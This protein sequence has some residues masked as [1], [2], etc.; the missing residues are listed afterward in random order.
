MI[1]PFVSAFVVALLMAVGQQGG[2]Q[3][4]TLENTLAGFTVGVSTL[5]DAQKR[6]SEKLTIDQGRHA[7][8]WDGQCELFL[9]VEEG[10]FPSNAKRIINIQLLN[11]GGGQA[12]NSPCQSLSTGKGIRL[13]D[14]LDRVLQ[15]YG[16]PTGR[17]VI[18]GA[19]AIGYDNTRGLCKS[20]AKSSDSVVVRNFGLDW[21]DEKK[22]IENI[23][24][25]VT[26]TSCDEFREAREDAK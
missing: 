9:D 7:V 4:P 22:A 25:G 18:H 15:V 3:T 13:S 2:R 19:L 8:R 1:A 16:Q 23:S 14:S 17:S 5:D 12:A 24:L 10:N 20:S 6:F 21:S 26:K 11:L